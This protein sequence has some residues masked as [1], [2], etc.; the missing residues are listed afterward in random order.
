[1]N[2]N[3]TEDQLAIKDLA[4]RFT[5]EQITPNAAEWDEKHIFPRD[6]IRAAAELGFGGIYV[7]EASEGIGLGR[8]EAALIIEAMAYGCPSTS[9]F[10][11]IHNMAAWMIDQ[12]GSDDVRKRF[13]PDLVT[14]EKAASYCL[15]EPGAGSDAA[16]LK[17][18]AVRDGDHYVING[19]KAFISGG[20]ENEIYVCML[21]TGDEG[22]RGISCIVVEKDTPGLSFGAQERKLGWH[23]QPTAMVNFEDVRV[24]V[25]NRVGEEGEGFKIA[26][27]GL[28]GGRLNIAAC[29]IGGAQRCLDEAIGYVKERRQFG[30]AIADFQNTQFMLA[31]MATQ[32]AAARALT[33]M[34][35]Q[36]VT[37]NAPDKTQFAAMA[38]LIATD[39]GSKIAN[40]ALQLHGGYGYLMDYPIERFVRD[41]RVHEI[42]EG[43]NQI[44]RMVIGR[45]L[46]T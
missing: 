43:T 46:V 18:R 26:M 27:A 45:S 8:I 6:T 44:M 40:D 11:S 4:E 35:A 34:A 28:D 19:S 2:Y 29:S 24:P 32:L 5:A 37:E 9:A 7:S 36:K 3:L 16:S 12:F 31:D 22:H 1:M 39:S 33:H 23:S 30:S 38:K 15:T 20:G 17:T 42:L 25:A 10:I 14:M 13:V 21:R 41:L